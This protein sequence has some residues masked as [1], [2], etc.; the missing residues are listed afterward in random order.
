MSRSFRDIRC[1]FFSMQQ[2]EIGRISKRYAQELRSRQRLSATFGDPLATV[3]QM[4]PM[5][6]NHCNKGPIPLFYRLLGL[7]ETLCSELSE[8]KNHPLAHI[9]RCAV[10]SFQRS[11]YTIT[12]NPYC[13][14]H[15][16]SQ[17]H[18]QI[19]SI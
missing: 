3:E 1:G 10:K 17:H 2:N 15:H 14:I 5:T 6:L 11:I 9:N 16:S 4:V 18:N 7:A 12:E 13:H 19:H 8:S